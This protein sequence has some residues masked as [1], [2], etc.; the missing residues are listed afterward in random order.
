MAAR[1]RRDRRRCEEHS[2][3][4]TSYYITCQ[5]LLYLSFMMVNLDEW[6]TM[7][8]ARGRR[9]G[10]GWLSFGRRSTQSLLAELL[11]AW[12]PLGPRL[13]VVWQAWHLVTSTFIL[14]G[15]RGTW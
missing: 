13:A 6:W 14:H 1:G 12:S 8:C 10:R 2:N 3:S 5:A 7:G 11:R 4:L 9:L 15:R